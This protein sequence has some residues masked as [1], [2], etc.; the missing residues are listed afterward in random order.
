MRVDIDGYLRTEQFRGEKIITVRT[1]FIQ[2]KEEEI[3]IHRNDPRRDE[4]RANANV[5]FVKK[6]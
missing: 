3:E 5:S 1:F 6:T 4:R 2:D